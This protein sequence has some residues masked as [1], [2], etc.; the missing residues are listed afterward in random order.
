MVAASQLSAEEKQEKADSFND[1]FQSVFT[2]ENKNV[3]SISSRTTTTIDDL[4]ITD[5][6]IMILLLK[7]DPMQ[8]SGPNNIPN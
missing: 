6:G 2:A 3:P 4:I 5:T 1:F 7:I 8:S